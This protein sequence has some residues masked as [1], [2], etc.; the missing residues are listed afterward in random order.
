MT[1]NAIKAIYLDVDGVI[2]GS[3]KGFNSPHP[4]P[5]VIEA[6]KQVRE[7]GIPVILCTAR[8]CFAVASMVKAANLDNLHITSSGSLISNLLTGVIHELRLMGSQFVKYLVQTCLQAG[9][10]TEIHTCDGLYVQTDQECSAFKQH[11]EELLTQPVVV[12][13][14]VEF[15]GHAE[16]IQ[17]IVVSQDKT[18]QEQIEHILRLFEAKQNLI[19]GVIPSLLPVTFGVINSQE[20]SKELSVLEVSKFLKKPFEHILGVGD[21]L[22][23]WD[24]MRHCGFV[25]TLANAPTELKRLVQVRGNNHGFIAPSVDENG[26]LDVFERFLG[27]NFPQALSRTTPP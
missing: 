11:A 24:F 13:D 15:S 20:V 26:I 6:L 17:V 12:A 16:I 21:S 3:H 23:D 19:W 10:P 14:L 1:N 2:T 5:K 4:H 22:A 9:I 25:A 27:T 8:P 18:Q 7:R